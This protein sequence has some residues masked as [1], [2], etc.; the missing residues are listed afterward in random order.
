MAAEQSIVAGGHGGW[1]YSTNGLEEAEGRTRAGEEED[2]DQV[3]SPRSQ[4]AD[5]TD[6]RK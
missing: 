4:A 3:Q 5:H 6:A 1:S 2:R